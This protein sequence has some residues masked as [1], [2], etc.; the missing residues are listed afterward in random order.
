MNKRQKD[1][2]TLRDNLLVVQRNTGKRHP[3]LVA[4]DSQPTA[5]EYLLE[6]FFELCG[7]RRSSTVGVEPIGFDQVYFWQLASGFRLHNWERK[8][9]MSADAVWRRAQHP[10]YAGP[11]L[12]DSDGD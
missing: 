10:S 3:L 8:A 4:S 7:V 1:G 2:S 9:L 5:L 6:V 12:E 11:D